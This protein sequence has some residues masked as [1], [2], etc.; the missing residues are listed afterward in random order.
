VTPEVIE[1]VRKIIDLVGTAAIA[2][3]DWQQHFNLQA[4]MQTREDLDARLRTQAMLL[5][6]T[7]LLLFV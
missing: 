1:H 2:L 6:P 7:L 4:R 5:W 3:Y